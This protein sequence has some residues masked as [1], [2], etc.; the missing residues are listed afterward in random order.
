MKISVVTPLFHSAAYVEELHARCKAAIRA[1]GVAEH[2][3][4]FVNDCSPDESLAEAKKVAARDPNVVVVDLARN[5]GQ[6]KAIMTG[7]AYA[8]GNY[9]FVMDSDL[10]EDPEWIPIFYRE[11]AEKHCDVV[12]GI[13]N[14]NRGFAY[15]I[16]HRIFYRLIAALSGVPMSRQVC[17]ARLMT[18]R[19]V[20]AVMLFTESEYYIAG[21]WH[22][23]GFAQMPVEVDKRHSSAT[24][25]TLPRLAA[26]FI[27]AVTTYSTRPLL[28]ISVAG[29]ALSV[30]AF[31]YT[32]WI[33]SQKLLHGIAV[34]GWASVMAVVLLYGGLS[35]F[36]NGLIAIYVAKI[37]IEVKRRPR[38][39][40][41]EVIAGTKTHGA[42]DD[43]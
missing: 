28:A 19:Y 7:L 2:E 1:A 39:I 35:L 4:V 20:D 6:H 23:A 24:T 17:I 16:G 3:I 32:A 5:Y 11:L 30:V 10:E 15:R 37:F 38:T 25:Y 27:N 29:I 21:I 12:Y 14:L 9:V 41:R 18:R 22:L 31:L 34:E 36:F 40:V 42:L 13:S 26:L 8:T 43:G 33:I